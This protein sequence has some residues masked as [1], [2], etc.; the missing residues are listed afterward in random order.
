MKPPRSA[1]P[2][3]RYTRRKPLADGRWAYF[4]EPPTWARRDGCPVNAEALGA[5]YDVAV[6]RA[7]DVLLKGFDSWR[8]AGL[9]DMVPIGPVLGSFDWLAA[10]FKGHHAWRDID[11]K[12][13]RLYE[14]GLALFANR[15][16][17]DGSRVGSK[18]LSDFSRG[19]VDAIYAK[20]LTVETT[21]AAGNTVTRT[22]RRFAN[23][24]MTACRRAWNIGKRAE[25]KIVPEV[26]PFSEMGLKKRGSR[27]TPRETPTA[28]WD[29]LT[30]FRD[31]AFELGYKSVATA[32]LAAW[33]W[34][35]REEHLLGA[36]LI[37]HYRSNERPNAV[38]VVHPK[39]GEEAWWPLFDETQRRPQRYP[40]FPEL[41][42]ELDAIKAGAVVGI[43]GLIFRRG[44]AHRR[45]KV[46]LPW[47]TPRGDL[48]HFRS[49]VKDIIRAAGLRDELSFASFRHG[50]F[51]EGADADMT[52]AELRAAGRHR[53]ARQLP[54]YAKRTRKQLISGARKRRKERTK[55]VN[56]SE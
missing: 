35:Q 13:Q 51:T 27:E 15:I 25:E 31:K 48:D 21:D 29:E 19:F 32:A 44:H 37:S 55:A 18:K 40:L 26:N 41:M 34:L 2:L 16:L 11:R 46:P 28:T 45:G 14:Q 22:R 42:A 6:R 49:V 53:S 17:K 3:P 1:K 10:V 56:L 30:A 24:A 23:A 52:D 47:I 4:F 9:S 12:T 8:T 43:D 54:T 5:D 39:T 7:E 38:R 36:F 33:E 20:L 50:G